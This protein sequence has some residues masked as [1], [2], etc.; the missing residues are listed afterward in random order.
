MI[1]YVVVSLLSLKSL[2]VLCSHQ[3]L[4]RYQRY[5]RSFLA[6]MSWSYMGGGIFFALDEAVLIEQIHDIRSVV[7]TSPSS[8]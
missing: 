4:Q 7:T 5:Q 1:G 3:V 2:L 6:T 8:T